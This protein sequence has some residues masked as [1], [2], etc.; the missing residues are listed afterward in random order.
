MIIDDEEISE[1]ITD[2]SKIR[3]YYENQMSDA[4][5]TECVRKEL[6]VNTY[7]ISA[8]YVNMLMTA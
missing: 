7:I 4:Y 2:R 3:M 6:S 8:S 5:K 1:C